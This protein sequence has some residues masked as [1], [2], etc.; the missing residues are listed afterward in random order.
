MISTRGSVRASTF[1]EYLRALQAIGVERCDS[2]VTDGHS[3]YFDSGGERV[4]SPPVHESF[5]IDEDSKRAMFLQ[6]LRPARAARDDLLR[7]LEGLGAE[8][9][10]EW[11]VDTFRTT[12]AFYDKAGREM[13]VEQIK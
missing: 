4:V 7:D 13:L 5:A 3:E 10:R 2:Y 1:L 9:D 6:H 11:T 12:M 8:R